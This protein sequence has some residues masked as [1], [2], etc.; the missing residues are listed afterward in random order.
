MHFLAQRLI[1]IVNTIKYISSV[2]LLWKMWYFCLV[3]IKNFQVLY[4][5]KLYSH[6]ELAELSC[7]VFTVQISSIN[8]ISLKGNL[9]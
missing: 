5:T 6:A 7:S 3:G 8:V 4:Y 1:L 2:Y 9:L